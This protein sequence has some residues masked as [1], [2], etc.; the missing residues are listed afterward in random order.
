MRRPAAVAA[1]TKPATRAIRRARATH[2]RHRRRNSPRNTSLTASNATPSSSQCCSPKGGPQ[3]GQPV[4][5]GSWQ[6]PGD[7]PLTPHLHS[8]GYAPT[9]CPRCSILVR[10]TNQERAPSGPKVMLRTVSSMESIRH[11]SA[12]VPSSSAHAS[13]A[14]VAWLLVAEA[15]HEIA[16][17]GHDQPRRLATNAPGRRHR[18]CG[19]ARSRARCRTATPS[20]R[21]SRASATSKR[22]RGNVAPP[23]PGSPMAVG[24]GRSPSPRVPG[25]G[26]EGVLAGPHPTS[27]TR[28]RTSPLRTGGR[29]RVGV[30]RCPT[31]AYPPGRRSRKAD[32]PSV[33]LVR[34]GHPPPPA[35]VRGQG[36]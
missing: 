10:A 8:G 24:A 31:A 11:P 6:H 5:E 4:S 23:S 25:R 32:D 35:P 20:G 28:P 12:K 7:C 26:H 9:P 33:F 18:R 13:R 30:G 29:R 15:Q 2:D 17:V 3:G 19:R 16:A 34:P 1:K 27:S 22:P 36:R 14:P 21:R